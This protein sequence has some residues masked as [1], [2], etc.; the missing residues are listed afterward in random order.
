M[1][2]NINNKFFSYFLAFHF[3]LWVLIPTLTNQN[4]PLDV[5]E[6]LAWSTDMDWGFNKH[7]PMS[8]LFPGMLFKIFGNQ[9]WVYYTL[10]QVFVL[11]SFYV[12]YV[13]SNFFFEDQRIS[14]AAVLLLE[15]INFFNF[16]TPEFNVNICQFP[17]WA[18]SVYFAYRALDQNKLIDFAFLGV[19]LAFGFLSKYLFI[20]LILG[21]KLAFLLKMIEE[22]KFNFYYLVPGLVFLILISPHLYW[23][24]QNDFITI[25][26]GLKRTGETASFLDHIK[27]PIIFTLKQ[28]GILIPFLVSVFLILDSKKPVLNWGDNRFKFLF[29]VSIFPI[30]LVILT[31]MIMG[32]KIRTMWMVPFY[33]YLGVFVLYLFK[34]KINFEKSKRFLISIISF[35]L[36]YTLAYLGISLGS[37]EKRTDFDGKKYARIIELKWK[38]QNPG[39][40]INVVSGNEWLAGNI[41]Y[42]LKTNP[43]WVG[44]NKTFEGMCFDDGVCVGSK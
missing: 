9:D 38:I 36:F 6:A 23:L 7:P 19:V 1:V 4:L 29:S 28:I 22:K 8:A 37:D 5:I 24:V 14:I 2:A 21:I 15:T 40:L 10:S 44:F 39:K 31:S 43:K 13:V 18:L 35:F 41:S 34:S 17:F 20:Y 32:S 30:L 16:V 27:H 11:F 12:V 25:K 3:I 42:H 26:Y 33:M